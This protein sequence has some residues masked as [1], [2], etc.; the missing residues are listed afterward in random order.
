LVGL[1]LMLIIHEY[2]HSI[3]RLANDDFSY[4]TPAS[5]QE[6][7]VQQNEEEKKENNDLLI[8]GS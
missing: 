3:I 7:Q 1:Q 6:D 5:S 4:F 2:S 8:N